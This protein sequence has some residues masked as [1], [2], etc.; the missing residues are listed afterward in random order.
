MQATSTRT[1]RQ[2]VTI[3]IH[4]HDKYNRTIG[5]VILPGGTNANHRLVKESC[6]GGIGSMRRRVRIWKG[7]KRK[8]ERRGKHC[9]L[10][11]AGAAV[12]MADGGR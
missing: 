1:F 9:G 5:A 10:I 2:E 12:G 7:W 8:Y 6:A 4:G 3:Q 11:A